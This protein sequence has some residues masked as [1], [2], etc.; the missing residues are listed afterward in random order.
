MVLD[1]FA[2]GVAT[3]GLHRMHYASETGTGGKWRF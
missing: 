1:G 3:E 2:N